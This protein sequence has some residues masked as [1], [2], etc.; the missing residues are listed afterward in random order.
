MKAER[1]LDVHRQWMAWTKYAE[2]PKR[3][4]TALQARSAFS[5]F[6]DKQQ[7][8]DAF[9]LERDD[10]DG[11]RQNEVK[12]IHAEGISGIVRWNPRDDCRYSGIFRTGGVGVARFSTAI[13]YSR[14]GKFVPG[15]ALK[16]FVDDRPSVNFHAMHSLDGQGDDPFFFRNSLGTSVERPTGFLTRL[17]ARAFRSSLGRV[18]GNRPVDELTIPL[19]EAAACTTRGGDGDTV[20]APKSITFVPSVRQEPGWDP[21]EDFR[22]SLQRFVGPGTK[23]YDVVDD[24]G[25]PIGDLQLLEPLVASAHGDNMFF[26][27]QRVSQTID[28]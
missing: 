21:R 17:L 10:R 8:A 4:G 9:L 28:E 11:Y 14:G 13:P 19:V 22:D 18:P 3:D 25:V 2:L 26:R 23:L 12:P 24:E 5:L 6:F 20:V 16:I 15:L 1:S 27:H 7:L